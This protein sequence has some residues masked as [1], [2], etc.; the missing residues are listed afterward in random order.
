MQPTAVIT[1]PVTGLVYINGRLAGETAPESPIITPI[2]PN[3]VIYLELIP[4]GRIFRSCAYRI[5]M[6]HGFPVTV[7]IDSA[8]K[9]MLYPNGIT[10]ISVRP[11]KA[12]TADSEFTVTDGIAVTLQH[13]EASLLRIGNC[14]VALPEGASLP[15]SHM[16]VSGNE[17]YFG[18]IPHG[19]Y[20]AVFGKENMSPDSSLTADSIS[21]KETTI[22]T[23]TALNDTAGHIRTDTYKTGADGLSLISSQI[24]LPASEY[25]DTAE[26]AALAVMEALLLGL[27]DEAR[28]YTEGDVTAVT[29]GTEAVIPLKYAIPSH[30]P[31]IGSVHRLSENCASVEALYYSAQLSEEGKW[32]ITGFRK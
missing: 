23:E 10:E 7:G 21:I 12:F 26:K 15:D 19:R 2:T 5:P 16:T 13:G 14:A 32:K 30:L 17:L 22:R 18:D 11:P 25:P 4:F 29:K 6:L 8:L 31:A 27:P 28:M 20:L 9:L 3:G 24:S 1:S